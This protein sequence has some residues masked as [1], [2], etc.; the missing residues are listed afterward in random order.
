MAI[1]IR[2]ALQPPIFD[3]QEQTR[4]ARFLNGVLWA[5]GALGLVVGPFVV[6]LNES[7]VG[8][9]F[10]LVALLGFLAFVW[11]LLRLVHAG[12][13]RLAS[14]LLVLLFWA[15]FSG[16]LTVFGGIRNP[17]VG[18]YLIVIFLGGLLLGR[19]GA[20]ASGTLSV[21]GAT[22]IFLAELNG[23]ILI[24][25]DASPDPGALVMTLAICAIATVLVGFTL[26]DLTTALEQVRQN[27]QAL[28]ETNRALRES[29]DQLQ[30]QAMELER[31]TRYLTATAEVAQEAASMLEV[32]TM[33]R[34]VVRA[35]LAR[36]DFYRLGVFLVDSSQ[37]WA[38]LQAAAGEGVQETLSRDF[39]LEV[40][41]EGI[42]GFVTGTGEAYVAADVLEDPLYVADSDAVG[43]RSEM[44]LPLRARGEVI[45]ALDV[46]SAEPEVFDEDDLAVFQVLADQLAMAISNARLFKQLQESLEA[47]R[48]AYGE[49][50]RKAW[51]EAVHT[52]TYSGYRYDKGSV[53]PLMPEVTSEDDHGAVAD[54]DGAG[55][56]VPIKL[57]GEVIGTMSAHK[58][59]GSAEWSVEEQ[60]MMES[61]AEQLGAALE[62]ARLY[63]SSTQRA[64][65]ERLVAE[66]TAKV[67]ASSDVEGVMRTAVRELGRVMGADRALVQLTREGVSRGEDESDVERS[68]HE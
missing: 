20:I 3:D 61:L 2:E 59:D 26:R 14:G 64:Q 36:F 52:G 9:L 49:I 11:G 18:G 39:R 54:G 30:A 50:G 34:Q 67:R 68:A 4:I 41:R 45:G 19:R 1:R 24:P 46:Q 28:T 23:A 66:I 8:R 38:V 7:D 63:E 40:G 13:V 37:Q 10:S 33:L 65:R 56:A 48:R 6:M 58:E 47:E 53:V 25:L 16:A 57:R 42:V 43:T 60:T 22:L 15:V 5:V 51:A 62:S 32:T 35:I 31:H 12:R 17:L 44:A 29:R 55:V 27:E 21:I